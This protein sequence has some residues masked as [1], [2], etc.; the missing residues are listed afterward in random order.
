MGRAYCSLTS[1][2]SGTIYLAGFSY[3]WP[4]NDDAVVYFIFFD[5]FG[6]SR[7]VHHVLLQVSPLYAPISPF[8]NIFTHTYVLGAAVQSDNDMTVYRTNA[9]QMSTTISA[10]QGAQQAANVHSEF[11][12]TTRARLTATEWPLCVYERSMYGALK[13]T[14]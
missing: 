9:L 7:N 6:R 3:F 1:H 5:R 2:T 4:S 10:A 8:T 13:D 11:V 12:N 14:S